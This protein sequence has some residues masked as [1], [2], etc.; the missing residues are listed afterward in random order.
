MNFSLSLLSKEKTYLICTKFPLTFIN[1][2][3]EGKETV[4]KLENKGYSQCDKMILE[5]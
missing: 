1:Q 3:L 5:L 4:I 2:D